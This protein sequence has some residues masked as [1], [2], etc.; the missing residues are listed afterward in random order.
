[1]NAWSCRGTVRIYDRIVLVLIRVLQ[2]RRRRRSSLLS[3]LEAS[4]H[5]GA[6]TICVDRGYDIT[7]EQI[8][9]LVGAAH[10][11]RVKVMHAD[12]GVVQASVTIADRRAAAGPTEPA[13]PAPDGITESAQ[14]QH[15]RRRSSY[16]RRSSGVVIPAPSTDGSAQPD[17][18]LLR[19][20]GAMAPPA[21]T[22]TA[23]K[24]I[25]AGTEHDAVLS[26]QTRKQLIIHDFIKQQRTRF[27]RTEIAHWKRCVFRSSSFARIMLFVYPVT[28]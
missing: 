9:L 19:A 3:S 16:R 2:A 17:A 1:M 13:V 22:E 12:G 24:P 28:T 25:V 6:P 15:G 11:T 8:T 5:T 7:N 26:Y 27:I 10:A 20:P 4:L 18:G 23:T 21:A 14:Y